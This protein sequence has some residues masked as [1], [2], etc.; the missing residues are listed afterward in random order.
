[1]N[2]SLEASTHPYHPMADATDPAYQEALAAHIALMEK[3]G[4]TDPCTGTVLPAP[5][6]DSLDPEWSIL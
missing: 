3:V 2:E 4:S 6:N 1:M 5:A